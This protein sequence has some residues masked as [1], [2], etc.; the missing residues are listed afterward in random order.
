M[1]PLCKIKEKDVTIHIIV[2]GFDTVWGERIKQIR[3]LVFSLEQKIDPALDLDGQDPF[4]LHVVAEIRGQFVGTGRILG[5]GH[6]GRLAVLKSVRGK[7]IGEKLVAKLFGIAKQKG[8]SRVFLG[9]QEHAVEF[10]EKLGFLKYGFPYEE[11]GIQHIHMEK[12]I[13]LS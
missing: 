5:D 2:E 13:H 4:S 11:A 7:G 6:I 3:N 9:A 8:M 10:Y 12:M 1:A